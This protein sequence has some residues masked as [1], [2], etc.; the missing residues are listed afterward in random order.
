M[1]SIM[2]TTQMSLDEKD[3]IEL[4]NVLNKSLASCNDLYLQLKQA[5]WNIKGTQFIALHKLFDE[6][7]EEVEEY[8]DIVAERVTSLG[9]TALGTIQAISQ[10]SELRQYPIDIFVAKDHLE[11]LTHNF[12]I[13]GELVR[14]NV[15]LSEQ[16]GDY[17][18]GD[19]YIALG[20][21]LDKNLWFLQAHLQK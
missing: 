7:A 19:V 12:A 14:S 3:R 16:L 4:V 5:H 17:G 1:K 9:G 20:R 18:T 6:L 15:K 11:H 13:F 2:H 21:M 10:N 8:V